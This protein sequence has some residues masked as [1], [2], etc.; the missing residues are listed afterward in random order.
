MPVAKKKKP[1]TKKTIGKHAGGRPSKYKPEILLAV[2][3]MARHGLTDLEM[4]ARLGVSEVTFNAWKKAHPEFLKA[5]KVGK[6]DADDQVE[7]SLFQLANGYEYEA[8]KPMTVGEGK[9]FSHIE[10][11]KYR[12]KAPPNPTACIFWL[13]NRRKDKWRDKQEME[14]SGNISLTIDSEDADLK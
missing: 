10:I 11:A 9:G 13:K 4:S 1:E 5:L 3:F 2:E 8:E 6:D 7:K 14:L 12:E